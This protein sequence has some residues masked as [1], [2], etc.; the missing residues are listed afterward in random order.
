MSALLPSSFSLLPHS[1][2]I[3][4]PH[5]STVLAPF[6]Y[7][8][9]LRRT[10]PCISILSTFTLI[11]AP[12]SSPSAPVY[13]PL[14]MCFYSLST[15]VR[16]GRRQQGMLNASTMTGAGSGCLAVVQQWLF[17]DWCL[18]QSGDNRTHSAKTRICHSDKWHWGDKW[19]EVWERN[20]ELLVVLVHKC[21]QLQQAI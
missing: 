7:T 14:P 18:V 5:L 10:L 4:L 17:H 19:G 13:A 21:L 16:R 11:H 8:S 2:T 1:I 12:L 15:G 9:P 3:H 6:Q 20:G